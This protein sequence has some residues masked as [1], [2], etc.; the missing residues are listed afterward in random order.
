LNTVILGI[1]ARVID[2]FSL[3]RKDLV[4]S[5]CLCNFL[6]PV[7][8]I[9]SNDTIYGIWNTTAGEDS[10]LETPGWG[11]GN[12]VSTEGPPN[13]F[14]QNCGTKYTTFGACVFNPSWSSL[15]CGL[16]TGFY[17]IPNQ[18]ATIL[19]GLR[20][21]TGNDNPQRD[22]LTM[23]LEGSN[24]TGSALMLGS[25]W[26]LIYNGSTGLDV[27]PSRGSLGVTQT[28]SNNL[29]AYLS[30]RILITSKRAADPALQYSEVQ[31]FG[32]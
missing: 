25:S 20:F 13:A 14:D 18:G 1:R 7:L 32:S 27:D 26:N 19:K 28:F 24:Q 2:N 6:V 23:T 9:G 12:Y 16:N 5:H 17:V 15:T 21:C 10:T 8:S 22:P 30:Y 31:L 4:E 11:I 3:L 29:I